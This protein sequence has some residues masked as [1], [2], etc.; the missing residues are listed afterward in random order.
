MEQIVKKKKKARKRFVDGL[1]WREGFGREGKAWDLSIPAW[2]A[3]R[4]LG[5]MKRS[6][7]YRGLGENW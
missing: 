7:S 3:E 1:D 5:R 2:P 6:C 4:F